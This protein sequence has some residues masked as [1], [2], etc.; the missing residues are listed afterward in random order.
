[1]IIYYWL[2]KGTTVSAGLGE[3]KLSLVLVLYVL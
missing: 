1:M 3:F 2:I